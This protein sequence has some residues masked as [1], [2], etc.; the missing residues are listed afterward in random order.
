[1]LHVLS[2]VFWKGVAYYLKLRSKQMLVSFQTCTTTI[3]PVQVV[4]NSMSMLNFSGFHTPS[5]VVIPD[6]IR[7]RWYP[8]TKGGSSLPIKGGHETT[9]SYTKTPKKTSKARR[10]IP[11]KPATPTITPIK[12]PLTPS[13]APNCQKANVKKY[14]AAIFIL[15]SSFPFFLLEKKNASLYINF[16]VMAKRLK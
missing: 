14:P 13:C 10:A 8:E 4:A 16:S 6:M 5:F 2:P 7:K 15:S 1:M 11:A 3:L 9:V 12:M